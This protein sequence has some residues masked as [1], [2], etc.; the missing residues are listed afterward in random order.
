MPENDPDPDESWREDALCAQTDPEAFF[1][2]KGDENTT[3]KRVCGRCTVRSQCLACALD[4]D[5]RFGVWG[6]LTTRERN[7]IKKSLPV[8]QRPNTRVDAHKQKRDEAI[9]AM[10]DDQV[11]ADTIAAEIG[12]TDRTV[13]RVLANHRAGKQEGHPVRFLDPAR[14]SA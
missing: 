7:R 14:S 6:G 11:E 2:E 10:A 3:A 13:Y 8:E 9:V 4:G 1:P 12:V 5:E